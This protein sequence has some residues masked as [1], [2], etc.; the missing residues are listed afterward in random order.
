MKIKYYLKFLE[1]KTFLILLTTIIST[2]CQPPNNIVVGIQNKELSINSDCE[3]YQVYT[4]YKHI[5]INLNDI[6][7]LDIILITDKPMEGCN[8]KECHPD[9]NICQSIINHLENYS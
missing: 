6:K 1:H 3:Q 2:L 5:E 9:A 4:N 7:N 8:V